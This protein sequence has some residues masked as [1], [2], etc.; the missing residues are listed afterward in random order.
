MRY[1]G[2]TR[3]KHNWKLAASLCVAAA[4][5]CV[6]LSACGQIGNRDPR[7]M[8]EPSDV[9]YDE[10][11]RVEASQ[12]SSVS[13]ETS[14]G[15]PTYHIILDSNLGD[16][17]GGEGYD[18]NGYLDR[19][20]TTFSSI[21]AICSE[22]TSGQRYFGYVSCLTD[23]TKDREETSGSLGAAAA[24]YFIEL[25][26]FY[27]NASKTTT[28]TRY[29]SDLVDLVS[30][31]AETAGKDAYEDDV[32][33]LI[34]DLA[35]KSVGESEAISD[36]LTK[37]V[38]SD[39]NLTLGLIGIQ[40]DYVG[41]IRNVPLT[42]VG[43]EPRRVLGTSKNTSTVY[44][45]PIYLLIIGEKSNVLTT[46]DRFLEKSANTSSLAAEGQ[47]ESLYFY[48]LDCVPYAEMAAGLMQYGS[49]QT[50]D[51]IKMDF[52]GNISRLGTADYDMSYIFNLGNGTP[53]ELA[54]AI[55]SI[56]F[57]KLYAGAVGK[58]DENVRITCRFPFELISSPVLDATAT[59]DLNGGKAF[60]FTRDNSTVSITIRQL[61][62]AAVSEDATEAAE[63]VGWES[64]NANLI[65]LAEAPQFNDDTD[66]IEICCKLDTSQLKRDEP[67]LLS[68]T[69]QVN[70]MPDK[71]EI[72]ALYNTGWLSEWTMD[73][74]IYKQEWAQKAPVFSQATKTAF[75]SDTFVNNLLDR[76]IDLSI[77]SAYGQMDAY[78]KTILF[79]LVLREKA[80]YYDKNLVDK[81]GDENFGWAYSQNEVNQISEADTDYE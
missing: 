15:T 52:T 57:A 35:M 53:E 74:S 23:A 51:A 30:D 63:I 81:D 7:G 75:L 67:L 55:C 9:L 13:E 37:Y 6:C 16:D 25:K 73:Q 28:Y 45:R 61:A 47:V 78:Q 79:G 46:M 2:R 70:Y 76:Q 36:A 10:V 44:R 31:L 66:E 22:I 72:K 24:H 5:V 60:G 21:L 26:D 80:K 12:T 11:E 4:L 62:Y 59:N 38:V 64:P 56:P 54:N 58:A 50:E 3:R 42:S 40:A 33:L 41:K 19:R 65:T 29:D 49:V 1:T 77:E 8:I 17:T 48:G 39:E 20:C 32:F 34:S 68:A 69:L 27:N 43:I 18:G 71:S 14:Y